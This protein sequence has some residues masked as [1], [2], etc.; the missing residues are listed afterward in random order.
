MSA[1]ETEIEARLSE[2]KR[3]AR[4]AGVNSFAVLETTLR[5]GLK[6]RIKSEKEIQIEREQMKKT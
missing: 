5:M 6:Q 3:L 1:N 4:E 2:A